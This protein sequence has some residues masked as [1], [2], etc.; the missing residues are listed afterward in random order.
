MLISSLQ[1]TIINA[2]SNVLAQIINT[3]RQGLPLSFNWIEFWRFTI[4]MAIL[5]PFVYYW[6]MWMEV[7]WPGQ[8][9]LKQQA[10]L[11]L[12]ADFE[13][14]EVGRS[15]LESSGSIRQEA[16][17]G[18]KTPGKIWK[19]IFIKWCVDNSAGAVW[20][21]V[22]FI[23]LIEL[24]KLK[25]LRGVWEALV[26]DTIPLL[27]PQYILWPAATLVNFIWI[28]VEKRLVFL[29]FVGLI[30]G[31]YLSLFEAEPQSA[32]ASAKTSST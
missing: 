16:S 6:Q 18:R 28:P 4:V 19:N 20:Y 31:V 9:D 2:I 17:K 30:W 27:L 24:F 25:S 21:T 22:L 26:H 23:I 29:A 14:G 11:P 3:S 32:A 12:P 13:L 15:S 8:H 5:C 10:Y 7:T 1:G